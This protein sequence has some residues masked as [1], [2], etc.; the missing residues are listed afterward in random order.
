M[1]PGGAAAL[2]ALLLLGTLLGVTRGT[3][4][5]AETSF[6]EDTVADHVGGTRGTPGTMSTSP[7]TRTWW[8]LED[9]SGEDGSGVTWPPASTTHIPGS[10]GLA[11]TVYFRALVNFTRSID[12]SRQLEDPESEEFREIS[13]AVVDALES[14]YYKVPGEQV[15]SVVFIKELEGDVFVEL[16]V[17]SEGNGDEAQLG[18]GPAGPA[19]RRLHRLLRHLPPRLPVPALGD[20][21]PPPTRLHPLGVHLRQ[22]RMRRRRIPLRPPAPTAGTPPTRTAANPQRGCPPTTARAPPPTTRPVSTVTAARH[23]PPCTAPS[24]RAPP[25]R[26]RG[27]AERAKP[28]APTGAASP[29][30]TSATASP[31]AP[32]AATR[33]LAAPPSPCEPNEFKCRNGHCALKLWRCDGENDCGGTAPTRTDCPTKAPGAACGPAEF[34]CVA[35]GS[36]IRASYQCD[37]EPDCPDRS[38]EVGCVPP[39]VVTLPRESCAGRCR[40]RRSP[41]PAWP[42]ASPPPII[43]WRLNWGHTPSSHRVSIVSEAG[44]G[45]LTIR[46]VKEA[47][48]GAYT[49]EAINTLGMVFGIPDS[50]LTVTRPGPLPSDGDI[51]LPAL[52]LLRRHHRLPR[53][54]PAP[55]PASASASTAPDDFK[56]VN[57]TVPA[58]PSSQVLSATQLHVDTDAEEFQLLDLS[59]RFLALDAFW[60]LPDTFLGDKVDA[61]GGALSY[62]GALRARVGATRPDVLNWRH[63]P[64]TEDHWED[65][66]GASVSRELLLLVLQGLEGIFIRA[67]YDGRMASVGLS[68][69][70]MDVTSPSDTSLGPAGDVEEC[71]CPV[72]YTGLS[73]CDP[74]FGHCLNCQHNTEGPQCEKCK[75]GFFGD[76]TKGTATACHPCPCPYTEPA[77]RFSESC[78]LDTDGQATCDACAPGYAGRRCERCAPGYEGDPIQPGGKC[79]PI[80]QELVKCDARGGKDAAGGTCR[81]KHPV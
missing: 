17:G 6:P 80:G 35:S 44:Q 45:T 64:F 67:V 30:I 7:M 76:A 53:H 46:D 51:P 1:G 66:E 78:F 38:D 27:G 43:T 49:C 13:E 56:G 70:A 54:R 42:L 2:G 69:V 14:E 50:I 22:R 36:C 34:R 61:Y 31:T 68:D 10:V 41:S 73:T 28:P 32:T 57:V 40:G 20:R 58:A 39:Q 11:P 60:A 74:V 29:A 65:E 4:G 77:R 63:V 79:T 15:V 47:D 52:L 19:G 48:Q 5:L 25:K 23:P 55:P 24:P 26:R 33:K 37:R 21:D 12:Y 3:R 18:G 71:R 81:C 8:H 62:G 75:P 16:D 9:G 59:R 72:G